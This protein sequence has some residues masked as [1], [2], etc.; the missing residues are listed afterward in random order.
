MD[1]TELFFDKSPS[2]KLIYTFEPGSDIENAE[3]RCER[4]NPAA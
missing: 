1:M 4:M 2:P 3:Y